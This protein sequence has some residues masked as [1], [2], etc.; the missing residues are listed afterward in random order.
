PNRLRWTVAA[1][2]SGADAQTLIV[3][4]AHD[5]LDLEVTVVEA[6]EPFLRATFRELERGAHQRR[7]QVAVSLA[8]ERPPGALRGELRIHT[9]HPSQPTVAVP[10]SGFVAN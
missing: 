1:D 3:T 9:N 4:S 7:W 8:A 2:G 6:S 5:E 10:V